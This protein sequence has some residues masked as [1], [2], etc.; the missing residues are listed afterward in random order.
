MGRVAQR[1]RACWELC[2]LS[3]ELPSVGLSAPSKAGREMPTEAGWGPLGPP[4][5]YPHGRMALGSSVFLLEGR[6]YPAS[7]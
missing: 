5:P 4:S 3:A 7:L 1:S 2:D 6:E